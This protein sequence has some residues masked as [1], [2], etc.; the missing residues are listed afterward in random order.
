MLNVP[1]SR[2]NT[3]QNAS[4]LEVQTG[5]SGDLSIPPTPSLD[6]GHAALKFMRRK[7]GKGT[8]PSRYICSAPLLI[9]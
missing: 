5:L 9:K 3:S 2:D 6:K 1:Q 8:H 7:K 4:N